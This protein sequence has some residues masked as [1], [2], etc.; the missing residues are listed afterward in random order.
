[1]EW[2]ES[3]VTMR[4]WIIGAFFAFIGIIVAVIG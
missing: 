4:M 1:L 2:G 3:K